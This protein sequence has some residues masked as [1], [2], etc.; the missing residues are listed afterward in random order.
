MASHMILP[1]RAN[2]MSSNTYICHVDY[3]Q[4]TVAV[5][6]IKYQCIRRARFQLLW[7]NVIKFPDCIYLPDRNLLFTFRHHSNL[8]VVNNLI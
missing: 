4:I 7:I 1:Y 3:L 2:A 6:Y 8:Q 5:F